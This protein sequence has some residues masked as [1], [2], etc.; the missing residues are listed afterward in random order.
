ME[1]KSHDERIVCP[2]KIFFTMT[3]EIGFLV[4]YGSFKKQLSSLIAIKRNAVVL[5]VNVISIMSDKGEYREDFQSKG[6]QENVYD[7][8]I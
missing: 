4:L 3:R 7:E 6:C 2:E 1:V 5:I 8:G